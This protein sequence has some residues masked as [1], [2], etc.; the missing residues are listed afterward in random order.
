MVSP[1]PAACACLYEAVYLYLGKGFRKRARLKKNSRE[2]G[3]EL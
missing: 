2:L 3:S 1:K